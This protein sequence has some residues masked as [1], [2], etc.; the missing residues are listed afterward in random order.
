MHP[1][2]QDVHP[3]ADRGLASIDSGKE[4]EKTEKGER[5][6][7][8]AVRNRDRKEWGTVDPPYKIGEVLV[9]RRESPEVRSPLPWNARSR[10]ILTEAGANHLGSRSFPS[11]RK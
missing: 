6:D 9:Q 8:E 1:G 11:L 2:V 7:C 4:K 3:R 10:Q 5:L